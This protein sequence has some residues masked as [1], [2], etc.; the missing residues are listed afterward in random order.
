VELILYGQK[1]EQ[2]SAAFEKFLDMADEDYIRK[3]SNDSLLKNL[4]DKQVKSSGQTDKPSR[5]TGKI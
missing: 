5:Q 2:L 3:D 4:A 1:Q